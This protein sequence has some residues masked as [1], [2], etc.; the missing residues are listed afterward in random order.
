MRAAREE[1]RAAAAA[2]LE[3]ERELLGADWRRVVDAAR[4]SE[5]VRCLPPLPTPAV[6]PAL[7]L[8]LSRRRRRWP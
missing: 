4:A 2:A 1:E 3:R 5:K 6:A 8:A 7:A